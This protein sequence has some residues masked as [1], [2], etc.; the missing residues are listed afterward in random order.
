MK[1][2]ISALTDSVAVA[3]APRAVAVIVSVPATHALTKTDACP[4]PSVVTVMV[5]VTGVQVVV[6]VVLREFPREL[7]L[8]ARPGMPVPPE[9]RS[10]IVSCIV[11]FNTRELAPLI[12][13][14]VPITCTVFVSLRLPVLAITVIVRLLGSP[15]VVRRAVAVPVGPVVPLIT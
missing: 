10:R 14:V 11:A 6:D 3:V 12:D 13:S 1:T 8:I 5:V 9:S 4:V 7:T 2:K 15:P